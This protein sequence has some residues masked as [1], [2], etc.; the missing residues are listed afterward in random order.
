MYATDDRQ[1][2]AIEAWVDAAK[3]LVEATKKKREDYNVFINSAVTF[4]QL[5]EVWPEPRRSQTGSRSTFP[6]RSILKCW[7]ASKLIA[8][9]A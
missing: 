5:V 3:V 8:P 2:K 4:E 9:P 1:Q 7:R 6:P